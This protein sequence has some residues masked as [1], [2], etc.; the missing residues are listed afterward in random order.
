MGSALHWWWWFIPAFAGLGYFALTV[1]VLELFNYWGFTAKTGAK[2]AEQRDDLKRAAIKK[3]PWAPYVPTPHIAVSKM[4][5]MGRIEPGDVV[6]DLGCGD[7]R[8]VRRAAKEYEATGVGF[9]LSF[10]VYWYA[11]FLN[12]WH[13]VSVDRVKLLRADFW[14]SD[15][16][17]C[18]VVMAFLLPRLLDQLREKA[19]EEMRPG[20][21]IV[22]FRWEMPGWVPQKRDF[23]AAGFT[24]TS[25]AKLTP[26]YVYEAPFKR[27]TA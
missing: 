11:R 10:A 19:I 17:Q 21:R 18:D 23:V 9:E 13:R 5:E 4:L 3:L 22:T 8:I 20:S 27:R 2:G 25:G 1:F 12:L 16:A 14:Q 7:G 26:V 6:F 15:L 24:G